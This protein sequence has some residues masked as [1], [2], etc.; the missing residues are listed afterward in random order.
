MFWFAGGSLRSLDRLPPFALFVLRLVLG[1]IMVAHGSGKVFGGLSHYVQ[2]VASLGLPG[3]MAYLST[4]AEFFGGILV[5][6]GFLTRFAPLAIMIDMIVAIWKVHWKNGLMG[7]HGYQFP[8]S[9]AAIA[10]ALI[11]FGSGSIA[12]DSLRRG[13]RLANKK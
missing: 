8:L 12:F 11:F 4:A 6:A 1:I 5:I 7:D 2:T 10:F 3:W 13:G 9:L